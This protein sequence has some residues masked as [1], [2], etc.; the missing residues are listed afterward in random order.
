M[1]LAWATDIHLNHTT[2]AAQHRFY[3]TVK[4]QTDAIAD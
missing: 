3:Q 2:N 4:D 1:K